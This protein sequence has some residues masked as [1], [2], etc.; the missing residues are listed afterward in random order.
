MMKSDEDFFD[1]ATE[2]NAKRNTVIVPVQIDGAFGAKAAPPE[3]WVIGGS[4]AMLL[5]MI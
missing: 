5:Q 4:V 2:H 1:P 3:R